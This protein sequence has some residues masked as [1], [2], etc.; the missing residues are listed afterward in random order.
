M[1]R[2]AEST[3]DLLWSLWSELGAPGRERRHRS[4]AIDPEPLI[5]WTPVLAARDPRLLGLAFDWCV[6]HSS[7]VA[8]TRFPELAR[9]MPEDAAAAFASF[10][11]ALARHGVDWR[12]RGPPAALVL[13]RAKMAL[14][15]ERP[16]LVRFR[17]RAMCGAS[18]RAEVLATLLA[19]GSHAAQAS[20]LTPPGLSRRSVER[21]LEELVEASLVAVDGGPRRRVFRLRD[22]HALESFVIGKRLRWTDWHRALSLPALLLGM[23]DEAQRNSTLRRVEAARAWQP[24][25]RL[26]LT[27]GLEPPPGTPDSPDAFEVLLGWGA[28]AVE[29][30]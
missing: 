28:K 16:A 1:S 20:E 27:L 18:S 15:L 23:A 10:S 26:G 25:A 24:A 14:P 6:A 9:H 8:K 4:A 2:L 7:Q 11:G 3:L 30:L 5:V 13:G 19:A 21:V 22:R 12:P 17:I 29:R